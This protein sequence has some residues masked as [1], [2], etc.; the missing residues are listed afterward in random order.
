MVQL[1]TPLKA[2]VIGKAS[3]I[4][5]TNEAV[6]YHW[7]SHGKWGLGHY[8]IKHTD[9]KTN[10]RLVNKQVNVRNL[11]QKYINISAVVFPIRIIWPWV[12]LCQ[13]LILIFLHHYLSKNLD[14]YCYL[15]GFGY[16]CQKPW[17]TC[18]HVHLY[19]TDVA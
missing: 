10:W 5:S 16:R 19:T 17:A 1:L 7:A 18:S 13:W 12:A 14:I 2:A 15:N 6:P 4:S 11:S 9:L 8:S 3:S